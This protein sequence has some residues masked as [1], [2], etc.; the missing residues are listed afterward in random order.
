MLRG[1]G[2][3]VLR[4]QLLPPRCVF[5]LL[6]KLVCLTGGFEFENVLKNTA[7]HKVCNLWARISPQ[8]CRVRRTREWR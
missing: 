1:C 8:I 3:S 4:G 7:V 5:I 2:F 6:G